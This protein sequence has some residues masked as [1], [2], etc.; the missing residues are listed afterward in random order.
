MINKDTEEKTI[1]KNIS[2][3]GLEESKNIRQEME[4]VYDGGLSYE[5]VDEN[6]ILKPILEIKN[7]FMNLELL[8]NRALWEY[9]EN[10]KQID[11]MIEINPKYSETMILSVFQNIMNHIKQII[12]AQD[13]Q[14]ENMKE[15]IKNMV[16]ISKKEYALLNKEDEQ[17]IERKEEKIDK[18]EKKP[19]EIKEEII[20]PIETKNN[21][22][23]KETEKL[24][25]SELIEKEIP[26]PLNKQ[27]E[28]K[29]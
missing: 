29:T 17:G 6:P 18:I 24:F 8:I 16:K 25:H 2:I 3:G 27:E 14:K 7:S 22:K 1:R 9:E 11:K 21:E 20:K 19:K 23:I 28:Q 15:A 26:I 5:E 13:L 12:H 4:G 10:K